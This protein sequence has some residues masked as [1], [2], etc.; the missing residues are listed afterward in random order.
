[1]H[2]TWP[3]RVHSRLINCYSTRFQ[4]TT[5]LWHLITRQIRRE[6]W[7]FLS[8]FV[9]RGLFSKSSEGISF[10]Y[11]SNPVYLNRNIFPKSFER[12]IYISVYIERIFTKIG[13]SHKRVFYKFKNIFKTEKSDTK[14]TNFFKKKND[15]KSISRTQIADMSHK[16]NNKPLT[17]YE[18]PTI[19]GKQTKRFHFVRICQL[20]LI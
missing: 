9:C 18:D 14:C 10:E 1:M 11:Q 20:T 7:N 5:S 15:F 4:L 12:F 8:H 16:Y 2:S 3:I 19:N 17:K 13:S 6:L